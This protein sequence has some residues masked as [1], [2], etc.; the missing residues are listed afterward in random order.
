MVEPGAPRGLIGNTDASGE[1]GRRVAERLARQGMSQRFFTQH[2]SYSVDLPG[3]EM[4]SIT[5]DG[6][7]ES[8]K[9]ALTGVETLFL[10]PIRERPDRIRLHQSAIDAAVTAGVRR[11]VYSSFFG[12]AVDATFT[13]ARDHYATEQYIRSTGVAFTF[14]RGS[15]LPTCPALDHR[16]GR[17]DPRAWRKR[18]PGSGVAGRHGRHRRR[19]HHRRRCARRPDIRSHRR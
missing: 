9:E 13:L 11:I 2:P 7:V 10:V 8:V 14:L 19:G 1:V 3:A 16:F 18:S 4:V 12:A 17:S 15:V 5:D 6:D